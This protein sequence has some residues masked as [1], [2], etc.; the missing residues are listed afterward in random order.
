M[1]KHLHLEFII[2]T[3]LV[4][5]IPFSSYTQ[6]NSD[7]AT[8]VNTPIQQEQALQKRAVLSLDAAIAS[9]ISSPSPA[10]VAEGEHLKSLAFDLLPTIYFNSGQQVNPSGK[11][12]IC[13]E[14]DVVSVSKLYEENTQF[15]QVELIIL[16]INKS[17]DLGTVLRPELLRS[18]SSLKYL[19][20]SSSFEICTG[21]GCEAPIVSQMV[22]E[23]GNSNYLILYQISIPE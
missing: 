20:I 3:L 8:S 5:S 18:F 11:A 1:K 2:S 15:S 22:G 19:C 14:T 7:P 16:K 17:S 13:A 10:K 23:T 6:V 12:P 21:T 9:M 4:F